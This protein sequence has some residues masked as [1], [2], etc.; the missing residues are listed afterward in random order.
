[1]RANNQFF[2]EI[3]KELDSQQAT[4]SAAVVINNNSTQDLLARIKQLEGANDYLTSENLKLRDTIKRLELV[5]SNNPQSKSNKESEKE[6]SIKD[7]RDIINSGKVQS[8]A[9]LCDQ[10]LRQIQNNSCPIDI[11]ELTAGMVV[12][13]KL[14]MLISET[15]EKIKEDT[16]RRRWGEKTANKRPKRR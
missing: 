11:G 2:Q 4:E 13:E 14:I 16:F 3:H 5:S 8:A 15:K 9:H 10:L 6:Q 7:L 12:Y 1:M